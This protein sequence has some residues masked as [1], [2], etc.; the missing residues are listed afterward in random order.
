MYIFW[1]FNMCH[2]GKKTLHYL[3]Q[4]ASQGACILHRHLL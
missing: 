4:M 3:G 2:S 1:F